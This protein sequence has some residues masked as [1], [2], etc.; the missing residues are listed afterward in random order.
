MKRVGVCFVGIA[1]FISAVFP[2]WAGGLTQ[3]ANT[4]VKRSP[5][6]GAPPSPRMGYECATAW[7]TKHKVLIRYGGHNQGG[8]GEQNAEVWTFDPVTAK[9]T[10]KEPNLSPPGVCCN[11][12]N[13]FD[14]V[15]ARYIR[16]P[17]FSGS[18]GWQWWREI[19]LND[20]TI[21]TYDLETNLWR[22]HRPIPAP[23][24]SPL[25]CAAWDGAAQVVVVFGGEGNRE[26]TVVYDPYTNTWTKMRPR[27]QPEFRSGGNMV[28][29]CDRN[30]HILFGAQFTDDP[31]TW[32]YDLAKNEW[33]D[34]KPPVMPPTNQNDAVMAYDSVNGVVVA[35]VKISEGKEEEATHR[36]ETW[37]YDP[38]VNRWTKMNPPREP[39][40]SGSRR[41]VMNFM[42]EFG[43]TIMEN[44]W[45]PPKA[46]HEQ[47]IWTYCYAPPKTAPDPLPEPPADL[48]VVTRS[49]GATLTWKSSPSP[50]VT[51]YI[52]YRGAGE[53][54]WEA[55]L[56][57]IAEVDAKT[58]QYEDRA[59]TAG[60][61]Y[62]YAV[63]SANRNGVGKRS[64]FVRTQPPVVEDAVVSVLSKTEVALTWTPLPEKDIVGYRV[65]RAA[66]EVLT[67]DQ[68]Q[69]LRSRTSPLAQ[70]SVG[71]LRR[72]GS[73]QTLTPT[74]IRTAAFTDAVDLSKPQR[75][76]GEPVMER[77]FPAEQLNPEGKP[78]PFA[79][80]AYR[81]RAVNAL[82]VEGGPSPF[83]LT[84][85]SPPQWVFSKE[86]SGKCRL[87]WATN[88]EKNVKGYRIYRMEGRY[89]NQP[90]TRLTAEPVAETTFTDENPGKSTRRYHVV[91]VDAL[92]QEGAPSAPVWYEREW[93]RF[94]IPFTGEWHQ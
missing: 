46:E 80:Y 17:S 48:R 47:Q 30:M 10:L 20:S 66:V 21:W 15:R 71:A 78:Y 60:T 23:Q 14:P 9:W 85:P 62:Y 25:R 41:R 12:Q 86:E 13:V 49:G 53:K 61:I 19:Y 63:A 32:A 93:K 8:G 51:R 3:A 7:D 11:Q 83:F 1:V 5:L 54:P 75:V 79:V 65:E 34:L 35:V 16:F 2:L 26:G 33:R 57:Q 73:F 50:D 37:T 84:I 59:L 88:P 91:A 76:E 55:K 74:P 42:P 92:G 31:H 68:L 52:V 72:I 27:I 36:L 22:N 82:G 29:D 39:D 28:Y 38:A 45:D 44:R 58:A 64:P 4:W 40:P 90:I 69:R 6:P 94:Y 81:I 67:D 70:P 77:S 56:Q 87:K 18:H 43:L 89:D 24:V